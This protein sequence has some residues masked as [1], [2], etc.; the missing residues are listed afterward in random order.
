M[1]CEEGKTKYTG[2]V[3][4]FITGIFICFFIVALAIVGLKFVFKRD[5][6]KF[7]LLL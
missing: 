4:L 7:E 5:L 1:F 3:E 2:L 6:I